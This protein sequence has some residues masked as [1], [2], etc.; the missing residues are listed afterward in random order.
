LK[1]P[2]GEKVRGAVGPLGAKNKTGSGV[3]TVA[4]ADY[5]LKVDGL[6]GESGDDKHKGEI[7][8]HD[9]S[10]GAANAGTGHAGSGSGGG[11]AIVHDMHLHKHA[12]KSSP[13]IFFACANGKHF[14]NATLTVRKAGEHPHE[15]LIY[16]MDN[17]FLSHYGVKGNGGDIALETLSLNFS[18]IEMTYVPQNKDGTAGAKIV[19]AHDIAANKSS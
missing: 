11:K 8:I 4:A 19:K 5:F 6:E 2:G 17:V 1:S 15:Y 12:D 7:H 18:K 14:P 10:F 13:A 3:T 9:F 16:K